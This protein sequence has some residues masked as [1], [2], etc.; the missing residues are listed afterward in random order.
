[1]VD[2]NFR[3]S[4]NPGISGHTG[5]RLSMEPKRTLSDFTPE[6]FRWVVRIS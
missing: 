1:V 6:K 5:V 3:I 4:K 2:E